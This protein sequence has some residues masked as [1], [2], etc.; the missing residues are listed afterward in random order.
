MEERRKDDIKIDVLAE[1]VNL[2]MQGTNEYRQSLCSKIDKIQERLNNL[3]CDKRIENTKNIHMQLK[4]LWA[5]TGGMVLAI[6]S[7]WVKFK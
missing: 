7:E 4:A 5:I 6:I 3:P 1:R 2:W